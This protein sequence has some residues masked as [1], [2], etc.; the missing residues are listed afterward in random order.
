MPKTLLRIPLHQLYDEDFVRWVEATMACLQA[1]DTEQLDWDG[2]IYVLDEV[3]Q[4]VLAATSIAYPT[5]ELPTE[6][7]LSQELAVLLT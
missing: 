7:P 1:R 3:Y 5:S 2:L 4:E 6:Y